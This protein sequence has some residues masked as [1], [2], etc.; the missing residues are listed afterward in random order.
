MPGG[1]R[2]V[3]TGFPVVGIGASAG[4]L[5]AIEAFFA[6]MP[7]NTEIGMAFVVVQHLSPDHKSIL[8]D[9]V[10]RYTKMQVFQVED[11]IEVQP[12]CV[13]VIPP[14]RDMALLD[15][16]LHLLDPGAPR[17]LRLP[18]DFFFRSLAQDRQERAICIVL[19]GTGT[20]GTFGLKVVKGEGGMAMAQA[21]ESAAYDGMPRSAILSGLV[22][23]VLPPE[24]MPERLI[25]YADH[26]FGDR[27]KQTVSPGPA[28]SDLLQKVFI[29]LRAQTGHDFSLYKRNTIQRR[30]ER[31]MAVAQ[32]DRLEEYVRYLRETPLEADAL[33]G[34][35]LIGV[36]SFFRDPEAF[37]SLQEH[38]IAP[39][40]S[41]A[42]QG[43]VRIWVP[44]C[45]T[46]EEAYSIAILIREHLDQQKK[47]FQA[48]IFA[49][50]IDGTSIEKARAGVYPDS[51]AAD[52]SSE[53]LERFFS[54]EDSSYRISKGIRDMVIFAKQDVLK[55]PPFSRLALISCRNLL[56]YLSGEAQKKILPLFQYA[57]NQGGH[58]LLGNSESVGK[59]TNLFG[60]VDK[61][62]KIYRQAGVAPSRHIYGSYLPPLEAGGPVMGPHSVRDPAHP[63]AVRDLAERALLEGYIPASVLVNAEFE[64]LYI[65]GHTGKYL[66]PA[67]GDASLNLLNMARDG[68][69]MELT[70]AVRKA[71]AL[72]AP[73]RC[74]GLQ[75]KSN[76]DTSLVNL[77]VQPVTKPEAARGLL[78]VI[79]EDVTPG[80]PP[81]V[82]AASEPLSD[83]E[84]R[85]VTLEREL[86]AK[87]EYLQATIEELETTNEELKSTNEE[88]Q[89][90][91][92][93]LQ[94]ANEE[95][96]TSR[97]EL[98]SVNEEL[99]TVNTELQNKIEELSRANDDMNNLLAGTDIGTV[100]VD[101]RLRIS[102]F[103]PSATRIINLIQTDNG[104]PLG[105]IVSRLIGYDRLVEDTQSVLATLIPKT[106]EVQSK[107]GQWYQMHIQPYRT[108]K[109][110]IEGA[111]L[112]FVE[113]TRQKELLEALG[114]AT[115]RNR[116][117]LESIR[118]EGGTENRGQGDG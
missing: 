1:T 26:A 57:L 66:E 27:P 97:E 33:F 112:T 35:L 49:T 6:A 58:L 60:V 109:N 22:D 69:R 92:E 84:Q 36:T 18:I 82:E 12:N 75:V 34:E 104:R 24:K 110:I 107:A 116:E 118:R 43:S 63:V 103:T 54:R 87:G 13:Y 78:M 70:T 93:E 56:I 114:S 2:D 77:I 67:S 61:K 74:E 113:I 100:F 79:F 9:L 62:W 88:A 3:K 5:A 39:L 68:I 11:G 10:K 105:D 28:S 98:Q 30:I 48:Q 106:M 51:I 72:Q 40:F 42:S 71:V 90:A 47:S 80:P 96:E 89:S 99:M 95:L 86:R 31:R 59:F 19:S 14:N 85:L 16:K 81:A 94:S 115:R 52:V 44:G 55:D 117:L 25:A 91:N 111:V 7:V 4:G 32:I 65:H 20:D 38:V 45:S 53:R 23:Y 64:V 50:D 83:G 21:P 15:G 76:G 101:H 8:I 41:K 29:L 108:L 46:G 102:R 73:V 17:G 37:E